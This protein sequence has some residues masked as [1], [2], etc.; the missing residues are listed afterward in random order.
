MLLGCAKDSLRIPPRILQGISKDSPRIRQGFAKDALRTLSGCSKDSLR[1]L[2]GFLF[3]ILEQLQRNS[4]FRILQPSV[5]KLFRIQD[6]LSNYTEIE[7]SGF[8]MVFP[9]PRYAIGPTGKNS[10]L[11][12]LVHTE[13]KKQ[14]KT[15]SL[16]LP[17]LLACSS[18]SRHKCQ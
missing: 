14:T 1:I 6:S 18:F 17:Y 5:T 7:D 15:F 3:R 8:S 11:L 2:S 9:R 12:K 4:G 13:L 10:T 16:Q